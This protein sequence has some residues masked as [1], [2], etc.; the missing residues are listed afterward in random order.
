MPI[1][2]RFLLL[3]LFFCF[4]FFARN[5]NCDVLIGW[6]WSSDWQLRASHWSCT[7]IQE[8]NK[9]IR[10]NTYNSSLTDPVLLLNSGK[11]SNLSM[12]VDGRSLPTNTTFE[13]QERTHTFLCIA[14][15]FNP[16]SA[17]T[18]V[19]LFFGNDPQGGTM[20]SVEIDTEASIAA[21]A[22]RYRLLSI[23]LRG[24]V[25]EFLDSADR[26]WSQLW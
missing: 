14:A 21:Q 8:S 11:V 15:G 25:W 26:I 22:D 23:W 19:Q 16:K 12:T 9:S 4:V 3:L 20:G 10:S 2:L 5:I 7:L 13:V 24:W 18:D 1:T 17:S 6:L